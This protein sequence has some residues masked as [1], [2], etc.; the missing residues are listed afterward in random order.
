MSKDIRPFAKRL[1]AERARLNLSQAQLAVSGNVSKTTQVGYESDSHVP[2][3]EY[4]SRIESLGID[5]TYLL[6]GIYKS[7]FVLKEFDWDLLADINEALNEW[8]EENNVRI[9]SHKFSDLLHLLYEQFIETRVIEPE[10]LA[11]TLRL[12]A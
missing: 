5:Q 8:A 12:V 1:R 6:F 10:V 4:L 11:R 7:N 9:P 3:L 2:D